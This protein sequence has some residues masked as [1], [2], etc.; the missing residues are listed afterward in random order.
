MSMKKYVAVLLV[1]ALAACKV[2]KDMTYQV[3]INGLKNNWSVDNDIKFSQSQIDTTKWNDS[4]LIAD[5]SKIKPLYN[6]PI[7]PAAFPV[8]KYN[9]PGV[10]ANGLETSVQGKRL[11]VFSY[12]IHNIKKDTLQ[13]KPTYDIF[14][15]VI[16]LIDKEFDLQKD[17]KKIANL[18]V[19]RNHPHYVAEGRFGTNEG[20]VD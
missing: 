5:R 6:E 7:N 12:G 18:I 3:P 4:L 19:S 20:N 13:A 9:T 1:I 10:F 16:V 2:K 8:A 14:F 15:N 17:Y 11:F